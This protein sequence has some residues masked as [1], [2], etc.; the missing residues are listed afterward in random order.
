MLTYYAQIMGYYLPQTQD[1]IAFVDQ[2][3][4]A[5]W[6][7]DAVKAMQLAGVVY[8][9]DGN[10]FDP[11]GYATRAEAAAVIRRYLALISDQN[12]V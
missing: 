10:R 5:D 6:A 3:Q 11:T 9:R 1:E 7:K 8:G 4:I 2:S 12:A